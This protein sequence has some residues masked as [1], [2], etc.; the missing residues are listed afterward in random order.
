[1][2]G[3]SPHRTAYK[4]IPAK[5][6]IFKQINIIPCFILEIYH[7]K[8]FKKRNISKNIQSDF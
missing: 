6:L 5:K 1:M 3:R 8:T 7:K 4:P 2:A